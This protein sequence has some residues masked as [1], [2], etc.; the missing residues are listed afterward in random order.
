[1]AETLKPLTLHAHSTGPNP[2]KVAIV[3]EFLSIPY[4]VRLWEFGDDP[5]K[6]VKGQAFLQINENGRVPALDDPNTGVISW[7]S[8]AVINYLLRNYD[9]KRILGP[10]GSSEQ[11]RVD[12]EKWTLFLLTGLGPMMGQTNWYRHYN[13]QT[14]EDALQRFTAQVY[15]HFD[16]LEGQLGKSDGRSVLPG[17]FSA[18]DVHFYPWIKQYEYAGVGL[19]KYPTLKKWYEALGEK[20]E[21]KDAYERVPKGKPGL[22]RDISG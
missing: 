6:G 1:M 22:T 13:A 18:V 20:K 17:G 19:D 9:K 8:G 5:E 12:F 16:V 15:R 11:D 4:E 2:Y 21:I 3:L 14:N 7:E 10:R